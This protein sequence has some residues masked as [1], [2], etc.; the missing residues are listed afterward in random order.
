MLVTAATDS[1]IRSDVTRGLPIPEPPFFGARVIEDLSLDDAFRFINE[2]ALI[3][4]RWQVRKRDMPDDQFEELLNSKIRPALADLKQQ[5]LEQ[6]LLIPQ[7]VYGYFPCQSQGNDLIVYQLDRKNEWLRFRFPRQR[8][9]RQLCIS[10]FF[11]SV[12][13][14]RVDVLPVQIV[15]MGSIA[16]E[17]SQELFKSDKYTEYLYFHGLSVESAEALS[18]AV[19]KRIR[20]ELGY[21]GEDSPD[22]KKLLNQGFRGTRYSFGYPACPNLEDQE[23]LFKLLEPE[24]I[25][26]SL[27]EEFQLVPEQSTSALVVVHPEAKYFNITTSGS[28]Q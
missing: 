9:G 12:D 21:A 28:R 19:H 24:R 25:D 5:C 16:T 10:D 6:R 20:A 8:H 15:T 18:E 14:G 26:I 2:T 13:E 23:L 22:I 1:E 27:T 7:A 11:A 3:R 17:H 4:G